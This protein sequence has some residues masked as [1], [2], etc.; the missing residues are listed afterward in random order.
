MNCFEAIDSHSVSELADWLKRGGDPNSRS[1]EGR[2]LLSLAIWAVE[3][4]GPLEL[5][6]LLVNSGASVDVLDHGATPILVATIS[7]R[8]DVVR[9]LLDAGADPTVVDEEGECALWSAVEEGDRDLAELLLAGGAARTIDESGGPSG[10]T[11]LGRAARRLNL[12]MVRL[13]LRFG[14]KP[15]ALDLDGWRAWRAMPKRA[16]APDPSV[17]DE[18]AKL[19][20]HGTR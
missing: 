20:E 15:D 2:P 11:A 7:R 9:L 5:V 12:E 14:A 4:G 8:P 10:F 18:I 1:P 16:D 17:W 3:D 6:K 19:L 13:L